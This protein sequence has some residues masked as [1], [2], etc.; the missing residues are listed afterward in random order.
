MIFSEAKKR[1]A[2]NPTMKGERIAPPGESAIRRANL[3]AGE[4]QRSEIRA[5][6][7]VPTAPDEVLEEHEDGELELELGLHGGVWLRLFHA[8]GGGPGLD[9]LE[10]L[11]LQCFVAVREVEMMQHLR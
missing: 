3:R 4:V 6:R 10:F 9:E 2:I 5:Q 7:H 8:I 1:S 11:A